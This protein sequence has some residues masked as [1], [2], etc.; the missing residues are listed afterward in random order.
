M[1][2]ETKD[3]TQ[4]VPNLPP[5]T[6]LVA[7][8]NQPNKDGV[9]TSREMLKDTKGRFVKKP[10]PLLPTVEFVRARRKRL[11]QVNADGISEDMAII[12]E[13]ISIIHAPIETDSKSGLPDAK[14]A[15]AK[16]KAIEVLW[17][18]TNGKPAPSEQ[19]LDKLTT[20]PVRVIMV[21][22]P[23][24]MHPDVQEEK[25]PEQKTKPSFVDAEVISQ[26]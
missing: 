9:V 21:N 4:A 26:N 24:L 1:D 10:K 19:E 3:Q 16:I 11:A 5:G 14:M 18:Y 17:L 7:V 20:Q 22:A 23:Q 12:E 25:K 2:S 8:R 15:L 6:S 13:L